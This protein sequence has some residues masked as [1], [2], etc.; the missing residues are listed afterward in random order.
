MRRARDFRGL[1]ALITGGSSGIGKQLA[2]DLASA[3]ATVVVASHDPDRLH[4]AETA[5]RE[6]SPD[7]FAVSCDVR[8]CDDVTEM[9]RRVRDELGP[10]D[11][12]VNNA[13]SARYLTFADT[14]LAEI[15]Q[16]I[17][18]NLL[19]ALRCTRAF[20]DDMVRRRNGVVVNIASIAA[21][22]PITPNA[23]YGAA[24]SGLLAFSHM[25]RYELSP[26]GIRVLAVIPGRVDTPFFD[27]ET[28]RTRSPRPET[29]YTVPVTE[30]SA[31]IRRA[32]MKGDPVTYVPRT[33]RALSWAWNAAPM[34]ATP[35]FTRLMRARIR[36]YY[37]GREVIGDGTGSD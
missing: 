21:R 5:V 9:A 15:E 19:G 33:L 30:V 18:V 34:L 13:G 4:E 24:K 36:S 37:A 12:L 31:A 25:L 20:L 8:S 11:I 29:R 16:L 23:T 26:F 2:L 32:I 27:D 17:D 28:F 22:L 3:G 10:L 1:N 6:L 7:S 35:F 14:E